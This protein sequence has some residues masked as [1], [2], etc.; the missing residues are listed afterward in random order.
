MHPKDVL[1][2]ISQSGDWEGLFIEG[3]LIDEG[4]SLGEGDRTYLLKKAEEFNFKSN[5]VRVLEV[6]NE[7]E[8]DLETSGNFPATLALLKGNYEL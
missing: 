7:D 2:L 6:T 1:I 4:H 5:Q 8:E 3:E